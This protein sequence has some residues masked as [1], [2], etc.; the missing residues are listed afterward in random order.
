M[1]SNKKILIIDD[2]NFL[3]DMYSLKFS[4]SNFTVTS[5]SGP[6]I[7]LEQ[8]HS[9][10]LPDVILLDI[11]M[12]VMDGFE[13]ME[14]MKE[15]NLVPEAIRIVLSNRGQPS[16]IARGEALGASGYIVKASSTPSEVI[17]KV[18]S[19][20]NEKNNLKNGIQ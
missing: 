7:A 2:D 11:V 6:E 14:K 17:E 3:L 4:K 15:E 12:P 16:D 13:L 18:K 5:A 10:L 20:I 8:L 19:I 9:G 1:E